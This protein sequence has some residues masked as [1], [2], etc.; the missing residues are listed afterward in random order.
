MVLVATGWASYN[1]VGGEWLSELHEGAGNTM[2]AI[3]G[4]HIAGVLVATYLH[5]ENLVLSMVTGTK[6]G[7]SSEDVPPTWWTTAV[8]LVMALCVLG[9]WW[10]QW[11]SA[12]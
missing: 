1:E 2:L 9:F 6:Q 7:P 8:A 5:H 12:P 11:Q 4:L 10:L 3:V